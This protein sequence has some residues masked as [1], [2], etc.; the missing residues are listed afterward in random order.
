LRIETDREGRSLARLRL[1][2]IG[3][4]HFHATG[5]AET[6]LE[7]NDLVEV[8]AVYDPDPAALERF[9]PRDRDPRLAER[10]PEALASLPRYSDLDRLLTEQRL[11]LAI[12]TLPNTLAP[13]AVVRLARTGVHMMVDKPG[14]RTA[15]EA[16]RAFGAAREAG[17]KVAI[18]LN[19][20]YAP[21]WREARAMIASGRLGPLIAAEA[22]MA[23]HSVALR[24]PR[25][26][27]FDRAISGGGI[28][29]WLGIHD[30][31]ALLWLSG[32][33][34]VEVQA[35]TGTVSDDSIDVEDVASVSLRFESGAIGTVHYTYALPRVGGDG[36]VA[37]RGRSGSLKL[38]SGASGRDLWLEFTGP[39]TLAD[40]VA[41]QRTTYSTAE[42]PGYG[43]AALAGL[44]DLIRAIEEDRDPQATGDDI[45]RALELVDAAYESAET[46]RR[47]H[48]S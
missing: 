33:R 38:S 15:A 20:R 25:N 18:G 40:P 32:E 24:N 13:D 46:G 48:L 10:M 2:Q 9:A 29:H 26:L 43:A 28:L 1:G 35:M 42:V 41:V 27:L 7:L 17:V 36:Y 45:V 8:V 30:L 44:D 3:V 39:A 14:A 23:T 6:V 4:N 31:D 16:R 12:V 34:V 21:H 11:N 47:V 37:L 5:W 22:I 19:K